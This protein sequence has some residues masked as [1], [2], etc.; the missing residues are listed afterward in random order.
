MERNAVPD[1][2]AKDDF[3]G[4]LETTPKASLPKEYSSNHNS[5]SDWKVIA[6]GQSIALS[7]ACCSAASAT[8]QSMDGIAHMPLSQISVGY[9]F[10]GLHIL[11]LRGGDDANISVSK[12]IE[13][14]EVVLET[15]SLIKNASITQ[16]ACEN[17]ESTC[18][19]PCTKFRLHS[20]WYFYALI[21][22]LDVQANYFVVL[23]F[24]YTALVNSNILT[25]LSVISV[26]TTSKFI[27]GRV[28]NKRHV[29]GACLCVLGASLI[30]SLD[31]RVPGGESVSESQ[32]VTID[33]S[34]SSPLLGDMFAIVAA[35]LFGLNDTLAEYSIQHSTPNEYLAMIGS[36]G[37]LFSF[38]ES[39]I[40]ENEQ[41]CQ[42]LSLLRGR[43]LSS[44]ASRNY[45]GDSNINLAVI[46]ALWAWYIICLLYFYISASRFLAIADATMLSLSLQTSNVWTMIF[47]IVVQ[48]VTPSPFF[49]CATGMIVFGVWLYERGLPTFRWMDDWEPTKKE[50]EGHGKRSWH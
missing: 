21:A 8:L 44:S 3:S 39:M 26:M 2:E 29:A 9:F 38:F 12:D 32:E 6:Y 25:S 22:F 20:P 43:W 18:N 1:I 50:K 47:S 24:R 35:L 36:F 45:D 27:L 48:Q 31:F 40:F 42:F 16:N 14:P 30:V 5:L 41:I 4:L 7:L 23:S 28:F 46:F 37:F 33:D 49:F 11:T 13:R 17:E 15:T 10:L 34:K 19:I